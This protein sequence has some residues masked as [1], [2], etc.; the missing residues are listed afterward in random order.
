MAGQRYDILLE[1]YEKTNGAVAKLNWQTPGTTS[2]VAIPLTQLFA[3]PQGL[4][5]Q[6][7]GNLTLA[8]SPTLT[9]TESINFDWGTGAPAATVSTDNFSVRWSGHLDVSAG[10]NYTFQTT[11]DDGVRLWVNGALVIDN[12]T[13]HAATTN[14][15]P[16][17]ALKAGSFYDI[18]LEYFEAQNGAVA[19]LGWVVPGAT[20]SVPISQNQL[21][22]Y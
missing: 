9:R 8:G 11:S 12:W 22:R 1:Y 16:P 17:I 15:S 21:Y 6:Y 19:K 18:K 14:G 13:V 4:L 20:A 10:G 5:A 3:T 2:F 7:F